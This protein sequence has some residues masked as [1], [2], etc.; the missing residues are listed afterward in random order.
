M[1][2]GSALILAKL[3]AITHAL[4]ATVPVPSVREELFEG[5][6]RPKT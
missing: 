2:D 3:I 4:E 5:H 1:I 6:M